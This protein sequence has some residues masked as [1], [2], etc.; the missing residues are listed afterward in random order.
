MTKISKRL[1]IIIA[2]IASVIIIALAVG[3]GVGL[4]RDSNK[5]HGPYPVMVIT[6]IETVQ[7]H[8][9]P[10]HGLQWKLV[11][12]NVS[13]HLAGNRQTMFL[14]DLDNKTEIESPVLE[15]WV[16][17]VKLGEVELKPPTMLPPTESNGTL[18]S[19][20]AWNA[21]M[22]REW[23]KVGLNILVS[24]DNYEPSQFRPIKVGQD[25]HLDLW[26]LP[27]YLFGCTPLTCYG[28]NVTAEPFK[29]ASDELYQKWPMG[30]LSTINHPAG[31][32]EW[33]YLILWPDLNETD[34]TPLKAAKMNNVDQG[35]GGFDTMGYALHILGLIRGAN[36]DFL[37]NN[38]YYSPLLMADSAGVYQGPG[39]G[40]GTNNRGVGNHG[41][42]GIFI[43]EQ[44]HAFGLPHAGGAY[45]KGFPY[46]IGSLEGSVYG[47]DF[48]HNEFLAPYMPPDA[49][50]FEDCV[51]EGWIPYKNISCY[52]NDPMQGG[53]GCQAPSY[54]YT[55][56][57][58]YYAGRM[59]MFIE[60]VAYNNPAG[61][62]KYSGG[63]IVYDPSFPT[64]YKRWDSIDS[65]YVTYTPD[66]YDYS[67]PI[68]RG[69]KASTVIITYSAAGTPEVTQVYPLLTYIGNLLPLIDPTDPEQ[70]KIVDPESWNNYK[71]CYS[72]GC[73]FTIRITYSD[74]SKIHI[75]MNQGR[76]AY[77]DPAGAA[78]P[79][80]LDPF[81]EDSLFTFACNVPATKQIKLVELLDTP[82]AYRD[83]LAA[84]PTVI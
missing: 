25:T 44:T 50:Y 72:S 49:Y 71:F 12:Y 61:E 83:G 59:Q 67:L 37:T 19:T 52:K 27:M 70:R 56:F 65:Q 36:G 26:T 75:L 58:D 62:R 29:Q 5:Q 32:L 3:L 51:A 6:K 23:V 81:N 14:V 35:R 84:K 48:N 54:L 7:T 24:A 39:G 47:F 77:K 20:T 31:H 45:P 55:M 22:P 53:S 82:Y 30:N 74:K 2:I 60:G 13:L 46:Q 43:H 11:D 21:V 18:Y 38:Q 73:D 40:L 16:S 79:N 1:I 33:P 28:L 34:K 66:V 57:S 8:L 4:T 41:Y 64:Q 42:S 80:R 69:V 17:G 76:R 10:E 63:K 78:T 15:A 68:A 9:L